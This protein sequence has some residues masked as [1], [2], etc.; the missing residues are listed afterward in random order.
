MHRSTMVRY[1]HGDGSRDLGIA[2]IV[3]AAGVS[4]RLGRAKQLL[5]FGGK[6]LVRHVA[7]SAVGAACSPIVVVVGA[8]AESVRAALAGLGARAVEN[9]GWR[10]GIA[11][12]LRRGIQALPEHIDAAIVLLCD[13]PAVSSALLQAL[14]TTQRNT[15]K[16]IVACRWNAV[17]GPPVLFL[18][19]R[20]AALLALSGDVGARS[21]LEREGD[22]VALVDFPEGAF[23]VDTPE[24]WARW[25]ARSGA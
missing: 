23:D 20:F 8:E 6:C 7:D 1:A 19:E 15:G 24:D 13:Q 25:Q 14:V 3:L 5:E 18:R 2:A 16:A 17:I 4:S 21:V 10:E 11:S 12:S 9:P 22:G